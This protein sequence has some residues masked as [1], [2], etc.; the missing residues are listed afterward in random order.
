MAIV[1]RAEIEAFI[2]RGE[3]T[4]DRERWVLENLILPQAESAVK[5]HLQNDLEYAQ[6]VEYLPAGNPRP[7]EPETLVTAWEMIGSQ[8]MPWRREHS[9]SVLFLRHTPVH[10]TGLEVREHPGAMGGQLAGSF[11]A[12]SV[13]TLGV[14]YFLDTAEGTYSFNG[15][16][17]RN[18]TWTNEP[19]SIKVTYNG[20]WQATDF[21]AGGRANPIKNAVILTAAAGFWKNEQL[22]NSGGQGGIRSES[23][24]KYSVSYTGNAAMTMQLT[25][26][27]EA[28]NLLEP[29]RAYGR[30]MA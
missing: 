18:G 10:A 6:H 22:R 20:G 5:Q 27:P 1:T 19:R 3:I 24:G 16:L 23:I 8:A 15:K 4:S 17:R 2:G 14:D 12:L 9:T 26:P 28:I 11:G 29:F 21:A 30:Y 13:L 25:I 7:Q